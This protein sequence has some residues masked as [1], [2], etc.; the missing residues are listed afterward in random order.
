MTQSDQRLVRKEHKLV[1]FGP[2]MQGGTWRGGYMDWDEGRLWWAMRK[3]SG[4]AFG[5]ISPLPPF[6]PR[7]K[8]SGPEKV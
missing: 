4:A 3:F 1:N 5:M 2:G 7:E 6:Y 8:H